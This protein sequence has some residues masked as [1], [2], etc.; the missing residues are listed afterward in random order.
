MH[1]SSFHE[2]EA[3]QLIESSPSTNTDITTMNRFATAEQRRR[4]M[5]YDAAQQQAEQDMI[6]HQQQLHTQQQPRRRRD[7]AK[8]IVQ[9]GLR[10][11]RDI[12]Q[13]VNIGRWIDDLEQNQQIADDLDQINQDNQEEEERKQLVQQVHMKCMQAIRD[14][15]ESFLQ[16][17]P[18]GTYG[19]WIAELHP[20]NVILAKTTTTTATPPKDTASTASMVNNENGNDTTTTIK[21]P[22]PPIQPLQ[23]DPRFYVADSDHLQLWRDRHTTNHNHN[24]N[25]NNNHI[26]TPPM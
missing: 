23:I 22:P 15:L 4:R 24:S 19:A 6:Q 20:E 17:H 25:D 16:E 21:P 2:E 26:A 8:R 12:I 18:H 9:K 1:P 3:S 13:K 10:S 7:K 5:L 14:H 11:A